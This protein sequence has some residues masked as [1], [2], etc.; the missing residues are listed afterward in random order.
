M[1]SSK[2][3]VAPAKPVKAMDLNSDLTSRPTGDKE[4]TDR[5]RVIDEIVVTEHNYARYMRTIVMICKPMME[6][7]LS[8][9]ESKAIFS[10]V[11]QLMQ[12]TNIFLPEL[13]KAAAAKD[14]M[15]GT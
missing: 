15:I 1:T 12:F 11:E 8:E 7:E 13:R 6:K 5:N 9:S 10:N 2:P 3:P 4:L 14:E